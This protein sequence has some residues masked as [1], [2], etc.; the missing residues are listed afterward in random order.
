MM[1]TKP[2]VAL[3]TGSLWGVFFRNIERELKKGT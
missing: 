1:E 3:T 2:N